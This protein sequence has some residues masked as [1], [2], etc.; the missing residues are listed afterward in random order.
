MTTGQIIA[1]AITWTVAVVAVTAYIAVRLTRRRAAVRPLTKEQ[2]EAVKFR[3]RAV[4]GNNQAAHHV[5]EL[6]P[7][8]PVACPTYRPSTEPADSGLCVDCGMYDYK[9]RESS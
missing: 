2:I 8:S 3:F 9:H 5:K 6:R 1:C 4:H 7:V